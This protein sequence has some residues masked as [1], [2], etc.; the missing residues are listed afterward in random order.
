[1]SVGLGSSLTPESIDFEADLIRYSSPLDRFR[2]VGALTVWEIQSQLATF[3][4]ISLVALAPV[5]VTIGVMVTWAMLATI[6]YSF[7]RQRGF[8]DLL[9]TR[10]SAAPKTHGWWRCWIVATLISLL[11]TW[12]AGIQPYLYTR[13]FCPVLALSIRRWYVSLARCLILTVGLTLFGV[14]AAHHLLRRA[15][16]GDRQVLGYGL[17]GPLLNVPYRVF[18]SAF[19]INAALSFAGSIGVGLS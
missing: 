15:G 8:P 5:E 12:L 19:I 2:E 10:W 16:L 3:V 17:L 1:M 11:K 14:T 13:L 9:E 6:A 7:G 4:L 18:L